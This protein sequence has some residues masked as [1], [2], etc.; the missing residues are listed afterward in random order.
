M[1]DILSAYLIVIRSLGYLLVAVGSY[2]FIREVIRRMDA[3]NQ[4]RNSFTLIEEWV[5]DRTADLEQANKSLNHEIAIRRNIET[6]LRESDVQPG[7]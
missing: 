7:G 4:L 1:P 3:E 2:Y 5:R 6:L